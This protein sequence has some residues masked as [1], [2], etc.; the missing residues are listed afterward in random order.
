M[1]RLTEES[2]AIEEAR[3]ARDVV[4]LLT[5]ARARPSLLFHMAALRSL[6]KGLYGERFERFAEIVGDRGQRAAAENPELLRVVDALAEGRA[7]HGTQLFAFF[8]FLAILPQMEEHVAGQVCSRERFGVW[9]RALRARADALLTGAGETAEAFVQQSC[10]EYAHMTPVL[11]PCT[12]P[13]RR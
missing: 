7:P 5:S 10:V 4:Y 3:E 1:E 11:S 12:P 2:A 6:L 8:L 13:A 9:M